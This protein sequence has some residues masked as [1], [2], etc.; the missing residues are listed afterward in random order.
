MIPRRDCHHRIL[1]QTSLIVSALLMGSGCVSTDTHQKALEEL[2]KS[3][4]LSASQAAELDALKKKAKADSDQLQQQL[5]GLQHNLDEQTMQRKNAEQQAASLEK[6]REALTARSAELQN[7]LDGLEREKSQLGTELSDVRGQI[8]TLEKK[9]ADETAQ[10]S[11]LESDKQ[12]L[13]SGTATAQSEIIKLQQ[14]AAELEAESARVA[15]E[16]E[17]LRQEQSRLS[18]ALDQERQRLK[19]E[20]EEKAKLA[21][22]REQLQ[23]EQSQLSAS[24]DEER[25]RLKAEAEDKARL[26]QERAAKEDEIRRLTKTQEELSR[27]LKDEIAKG[28]ITIQ[29][30]RDRLTI[31]MVDR[32]LFDSGRADIK[33]AG[34][35]VLKQVSD[36][37]SKV[38]DKQ[39]RIEGHT[40]NVPISTKLQDK[41]KTNWELS[42]ARATIV[43]RYLIDQ[44]GVQREVLSAVGY[45]D[46]HPIASNDSEQGRSSNRRIEIVLYPKDLSQIAGGLPPAN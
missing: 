1:I 31:N 45:A 16:R 41:F 28:N 24:L 46:T 22:E 35:K 37:L 43:V 29:Q 33:P 40:D 36:V 7:R 12:Q 25:N 14:R 15:K 34:V 44:G 32:V 26:E 2:E 27:S 6:E 4:K 3:K 18:A 23:Q 19:T 8:A 11:A 5:A 13:A 20:T 38:G 21:K 9:L 17:Q 39:I 42:T 30:V 10:V